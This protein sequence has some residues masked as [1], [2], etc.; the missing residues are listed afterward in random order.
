MDDYL[1]PRPANLSHTASVVR[2][3]QR[4]NL[5]TGHVSISGAHEL[6]RGHQP[7]I[8]LYQPVRY[9]NTTTAEPPLLAIGFDAEHC[10]HGDA[11]QIV[12]QVLDLPALA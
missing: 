4:P 11:C 2:S 12:K 6:H 10:A 5:H 1:Y 8:A 9:R 7:H 3:G